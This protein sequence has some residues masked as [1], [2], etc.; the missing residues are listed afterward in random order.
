[1]VKSLIFAGFNP[2]GAKSK[3]TSIKKLIRETKAT[4]VTMQETK[5][6]QSGHMKF[7]GFHTYEHLRS[8]KDGG[9]VALSVLKDLNPSYVCDGGEEV[10]ALTVDIHLRNM[11]VSV[12]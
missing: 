5:Y 12:T 1:M 2:D 4:I 11:E 6:I 3:M 8:I 9:G 10:E 7:E